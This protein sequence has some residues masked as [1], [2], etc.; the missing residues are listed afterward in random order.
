MLPRVVLRSTVRRHRLGG[1]GCS[2]PTMV[3]TGSVVRIAERDGLYA[4]ALPQLSFPIATPR[5]LSAPA[6]MRRV[7]TANSRTRPSVFCSHD[8]AVLLRRISDPVMRDQLAHLV[9]VSA[10]PK[11]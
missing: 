4:P 2:Y 11:R 7:Q 8:E 6:R 3:Q 10:L 5:T 1:R 9:N